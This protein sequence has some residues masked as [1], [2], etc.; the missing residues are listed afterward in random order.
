MS[1]K[2]NPRRRK[3]VAPIVA[4]ARR[5]CLDEFEPLWR[6]A[7]HW[8]AKLPAS[9][10][11]SAQDAARARAYA[12]LRAALAADPGGPWRDC[13]PFEECDDVEAMRRAWILLR[14]VT[15]ADV[16]RW[17]EAEQ[18][19]HVAGVANNSPVDM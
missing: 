14:R 12:W 8:P 3:L 10:H 9:E 6:P 17:A 4:T 11:A 5:R 18:N 7:P 15:I 19:K 2:R 13:E 16:W 1:R